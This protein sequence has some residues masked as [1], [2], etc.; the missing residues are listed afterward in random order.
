MKRLL[1]HGTVHLIR[2]FANS[3]LCSLSMEVSWRTPLNCCRRPVF[4]FGRPT[5]RPI[6]CRL[7]CSFSNL[8]YR[9]VL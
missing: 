7:K 2:T 3:F 1:V 4:S 9:G 6:P 5:P 8:Q